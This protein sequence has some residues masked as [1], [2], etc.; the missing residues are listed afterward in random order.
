MLI[1]L[2]AW[3]MRRLHG[4]RVWRAALRA[5]PTARATADHVTAHTSEALG[6][7]TMTQEF[8]RH[9]TALAGRSF[10]LGEARS[11]LR[12]V[13]NYLADRWARRDGEGR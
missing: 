10:T 1:D 11:V 13:E 5:Y 4:R 7:Y 9:L 12:D 2:T 6:R 8:H 3:K